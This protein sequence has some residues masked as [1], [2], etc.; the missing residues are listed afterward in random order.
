MHRR[1]IGVILTFGIVAIAIAAGPAFAQAA[2]EP[3]ETTGQGVSQQLQAPPVIEPEG[4]EEESGVR[5]LAEGSFLARA[6]GRMVRL[7]SGAWAF[8]FNPDAEGEEPLAPMVV[9][10]SMQLAAMEQIVEATSGPTSF[11]VNG[12][13]F[14]YRDRNFLLPTL[15]AVLSEAPPEEEEAP[16]GAEGEAALGQPDVSVDDLIDALDRA[17]PKVE[18]LTPTPDP[19]ETP[20]GLRQ[21]GELLTLRRGRVG[22][23]ED[24]SWTFSIDNDVDS[25]EATDPPMTILPCLNL[26][27][28]EERAQRRSGSLPV[29][30]S[31]RIFVYGGRNY[32]M[33]TMFVEQRSRGADLSSGQ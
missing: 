8:V 4:A 28:I 22:R 7:G 15:H 11:M 16:A 26:E 30:L 1:G 9:L 14:T 29:V 6:R 5:T 18:R 33:P 12:Q 31:G 2:Q 17:T 24:G 32:V 25:E 10:P 27:R 19:R 3:G 20:K 21:E 13:V 23:S